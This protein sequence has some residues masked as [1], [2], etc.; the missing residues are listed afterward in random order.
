MQTFFSRLPRFA[1]QLLPFVHLPKHIYNKISAS[2]Q[3]SKK[4]EAIYPKSL[5]ILP[6][7]KRSVKLSG[8]LARAIRPASATTLGVRTAKIS[9]VV[10]LAGAS[11]Q[12]VRARLPAGVAAL[13]Y[14][15]AVRIVSDAAGADIDAEA[16][17]AHVDQA[18]D[19]NR[20]VLPCGEL[21]PGVEDL[22]V[23]RDGRRATVDGA[24]RARHAVSQRD[25]DTAALGDRVG[26]L[27]CVGRH[28][29]RGV[30]VAVVPQDEDDVNAG[31]VGEGED[32]GPVVGDPDVTA[33]A[34]WV[35]AG[36]GE[37]NLREVLAVG[38]VEPLD[39]A[40]AVEGPS[41]KAGG[42][43]GGSVPGAE[44]SCQPR[45]LYN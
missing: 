25:G 7:D 39:G 38:L 4:I 20:G 15:R 12:A 8:N 5:P 19:V 17:A 33:A 36:P 22:A 44:V 35:G 10:L 41:V 1:S 26:Q 32:I 45:V 31:L 14:I 9:I 29:G 24:V 37:A 30:A 23:G 21:A 3:R 28:E 42:R 11:D 34:G 27:G 6:P 13:A 43:A 18:R 40:A 2:A 16:I